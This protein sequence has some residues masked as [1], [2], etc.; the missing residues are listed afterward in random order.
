MKL[1]P[2]KREFHSLFI[3]I[4]LLGVV[5]IA[6][7]LLLVSYKTNNVDMLASQLFF[8]IAALWLVTFGYL[9]R[10]MLTA[11][12]MIVVATHSHIH[13]GEKIYSMADLKKVKIM[14]AGIQLEFGKTNFGISPILYRNAEEFV[15]FI[16]DNCPDHV[17]FL[18][19][20]EEF[21]NQSM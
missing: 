8:L 20:I 4:G 3:V 11:Y 14:R 13:I 12:K 6:A 5:P 2:D 18:T 16:L 1:I 17:E 15:E 9:G 7:A 10:K 19:N 21:K